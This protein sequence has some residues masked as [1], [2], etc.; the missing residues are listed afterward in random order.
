MCAFT[1][2]VFFGKL[3]LSTRQINLAKSAK[4]KLRQ[5]GK[6]KETIANGEQQ[7]YA[8]FLVKL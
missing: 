7:R 2:T 4:I 6:T 5:S 3:A 1:M 8:I